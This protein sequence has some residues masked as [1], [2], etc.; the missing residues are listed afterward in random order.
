MTQASAIAGDR[1]PTLAAR[2]KRPKDDPNRPKRP[3]GK[4]N[5][6][7]FTDLALRQLQLPK[8]G[9]KRVWD[10]PKKQRG[11]DE[12]R[13]GTAGLSVLLSAGGARTYLA[14]F[15]LHGRLI[16]AKLG[17]VGEIGLAKARE[18]TRDYREK[19]AEG[20]DPRPK[21]LSPT[22]EI[23]TVEGNAANPNSYQTVVDQFIEHYAKPKQR[24]WG[25]TKRILTKNCAVWLERDFKSITKADVR[26]LL[27]QL[28]SD[29]HG[30][31]AEVTLA[32][33]RKLWRWAAEEEIVEA[34]LMDT[35]KVH[36]E[37]KERDR[38]YSDDEI[39]KIWNAADKLD[40]IER[41]YVKLLMLLA[42]RKTALACLCKSHLDNPQQPTLWTT[43]FELTKS[44]KAT[45]KNKRRVYLIPL[46]PLAQRILKARV[47]E[48]QERLFPNL[49]IYL[50]K[51]DGRRW[52]DGHRLT[53]SLV[54]HGAP[55]DF[56][57]HGVRHT[58]TT[59][60][61]VKGHSEWERGL[62][63][64]HA[65]SGSVT[66]DYSHGF[67]HDLKLKLLTKWADHVEG[68]VRP[69]GATLLR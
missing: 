38:V 2:S 1:A 17:R 4:P 40:K 18:L 44:R 36:Y 23:K 6:K 65:G 46:P 43:P 25:N 32:W 14:T 41:D 50:A 63:L 35:I 55:K 53:D 45:R 31:K 27:R 7:F 37:K 42:P 60:L 47:S 33:L 48:S 28:V 20:N 64:N 62:V 21:K 58:I 66:A 57:Y 54:A 69:K 3:K 52:F 8:E 11:Q 19:A 24:S 10:D 49:P 51:D 30:P 68:L 39:R 59:W 26:T 29:G 22:A 15:R 5:R 56:T 34:P 13:K 16:T 9:Q 12:G 61:E 67:A